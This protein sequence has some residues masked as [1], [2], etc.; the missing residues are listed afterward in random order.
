MRNLSHVAA[1]V[2]VVDKGGFAAAAP[3]LGLTVQAVHKAVANMEAELGLQ[4]LARASR[5]GGI[6]LTEAGAVYLEGCR[7]VLAAVE[8]TKD[9]LAGYHNAEGRPLQVSM[10]PALGRLHLVPALGGFLARHPGVRVEALLTSRPLGAADEG[11]DVVFCDAED[12]EPR[13][14][15][16]ILVVPVFRISASPAYLARRGT[17]R[18]FADLQ[19]GGHECISL[20][21]PATGNPLHWR[22]RAAN[23]GLEARRMRGRV[24]VADSDAGLAAAA[25]GLGV[26]QLPDHIVGRALAAGQ[27]VEVLP[28]HRHDGRPVM[29]GHHPNRLLRPEVPAFIEY[30]VEWFASAKALL[31]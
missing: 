20:L 1:F 28:E 18:T 6:K 7:R 2:A 22:F 12:A 21:S 9:A 27:L 3:Q 14:T 17:P 16:R 4:L 25:A 24:A 11:A 26:A 29:I 8:E 10:P 15:F 31:A 19:N 13:M 23:G 30:F 5:L